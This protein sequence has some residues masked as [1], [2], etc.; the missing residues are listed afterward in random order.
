[1]SKINY[2]ETYFQHDRYARQDSKIKAMLQYYRKENEYKAKAAICVFWWIVEDMHIDNYP[3]EKL[4]VFADDYRCDVEFLKSIL[5]DFGL[6][7]IENGCYVS[8]RVLRNIQ[9]QKQKSEKAKKSAQKRWKNQK[10][11]PQ[12]EEKENIDMDFVA[13]VIQIYN[14]EFRKT[15]II[16]NSNKEKIYSLSKDNNITL[17]IWKLVFGNAKRGWNFENK[18]D[19]KII[20]KK[21]NLKQILDN[22]DMFASDNYQLAPKALEESKFDVSKIENAKDFISR[23]YS[24]YTYLCCS[25]DEFCKLDEVNQTKYLEIFLSTYEKNQDEN[26]SILQITQKIKEDYAKK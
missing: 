9:I 12:K 5:E 10:E 25:S 19:K 20:N 8:D 21:P 16:S 11:A 23:N 18:N 1:M 2:K 3:I 6:F 17:D 4:E 7:R 26:K 24:M 13:Q 15:Q 14:K 22:W